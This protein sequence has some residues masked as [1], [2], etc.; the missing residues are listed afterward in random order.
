MAW[1]GVFGSVYRGIGPPWVRGCHGPAARARFCLGRRVTA[2]AARAMGAGVLRTAARER[3]E[4]PSATRNA[5]WGRRRWFLPMGC[6]VYPRI[7]AARCDAVWRGVFG[8]VYRG[9][10]PP[11]GR[12]CHGPA[13]CARARRGRRVPAPAARAV[14]AGLSRARRAPWV[15]AC[16]VHAARKRFERPSAARNAACSTR[17]RPPPGLPPAPAVRGLEGRS[18]PSEIV[19]PGSAGRAGSLRPQ[20]Q[21]F[22]TRFPGRAEGAGETCAPVGKDRQR[23]AFPTPAVRR[24]FSAAPYSMTASA[25]LTSSIRRA[26]CAGVSTG[27]LN[28]TVWFT[29]T[30]GA[31][32]GV[33]RLS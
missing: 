16:P 9:I 22:L 25:S 3:F 28:S 8:T 11:W 20:A 23:R 1:R 2:P 21:T 14:G 29:V 18:P 26:T 19:S 32:C 30:A 5:A 17:H 10:G 6:V 24:G 15:R 12:G 7:Y 13:A 33:W 27:W 31:A 4:R